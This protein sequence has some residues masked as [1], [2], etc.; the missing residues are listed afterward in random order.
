[1]LLVFSFLALSG[2]SDEPKKNTPCSL[3]CQIIEMLDPHKA[4]VVQKI[5]ANKA[6]DNHIVIITDKDTR[7]GRDK[8]EFRFED[9]QVGMTI[10][11]EGVELFRGNHPRQV[12][13]ILAQVIHPTIH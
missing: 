13:A 10:Y 12:T 7:I 5:P 11:V 9:L 3:T 6:T 2:F 1:L 8:E 4:V